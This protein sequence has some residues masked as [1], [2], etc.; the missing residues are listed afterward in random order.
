MSE[1]KGMKSVLGR[2]LL[3]YQ[4][5]GEWCGFWRNLLMGV[6]FDE[7]LGDEEVKLYDFS[8]LS[9]ELKQSSCMQLWS[10][11]EQFHIWG[12]IMSLLRLSPHF[13]FIR[14]PFHGGEIRGVQMFRYLRR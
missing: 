5:K 8:K 4:E 9:G 2:P 10:S 7:G 12:I 6:G 3:I 11:W 14:H 1:A 13:H